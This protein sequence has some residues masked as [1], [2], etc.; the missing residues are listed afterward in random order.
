[1]FFNQAFNQA[2]Q[3]FKGLYICRS[4]IKLKSALVQSASCLVSGKV[5]VCQRTGRA[6]SFQ[7]VWG[8]GCDSKQHTPPS[9]RG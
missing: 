7:P 8:A 4:F 2:F 5:T 3:V 6:R 9:N 1:M